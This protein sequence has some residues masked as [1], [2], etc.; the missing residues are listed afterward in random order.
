L[1]TSNQMKKDRM[2]AGGW[3][4]KYLGVCFETQASPASLHD[5]RFPSVLLKRDEVYRKKTVF[6]FHIRKI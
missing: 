4:R 5:Q 2:L 1:Y 3:S 6:S